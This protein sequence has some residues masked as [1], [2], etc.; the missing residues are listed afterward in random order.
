MFKLDRTDRAIL[1]A[2]QI[3]GRISN[4][5]LAKQV[6]ISAPACWKRLKR[7]EDQFVIAY[8]ARMNLKALGFGL[9]AFISIMLDDHSEAAMSAFEAAVSAMP[10]VIGCHNVSG[11]YDYLL[12]VVAHDMEDF[13]EIAMRR[14]RAIGH[15][16]EI[17]THFSIREIKQSGSLPL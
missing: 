16:K 12:Q 11:K 13:H 4:S 14:I 8:G 10:E 7:L 2:L 15:I 6:G 5:D 17:Y 3:D 1:T 9:F